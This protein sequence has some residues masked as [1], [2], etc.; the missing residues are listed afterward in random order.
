MS[1]LLRY[2][3]IAWVVGVGLIT[4]VLVGL[5]LKY[6]ADS[7]GVVQIV[8]PAHGFLYIVYLLATLDLAIRQRWQVPRTLLLMAA[9]TVPFL[10]FVAERYATRLVTGAPAAATGAPP[11]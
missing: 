4:L 2:R 3:I 1:A 5:P 8:G 11:S 10:S 9:G 7:P 6:A